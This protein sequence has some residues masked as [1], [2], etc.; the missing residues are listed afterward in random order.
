MKDRATTNAT[1]LIE[2]NTT[3]TITT[4]TTHAR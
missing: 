3:T 1:L 4:T 2:V